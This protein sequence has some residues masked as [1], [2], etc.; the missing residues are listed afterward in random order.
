MRKIIFIMGLLLTSAVSLA[1][2]PQRMSYQAVV[3]DGS[4]ALVSNS[5]VGMRVSILQGSPSGTAQYVETH[6]TSTNANGLVTVSIGSGTVV[7]GSMGA[8]DWSAGPYYIKTETDPTGGTSYTIVGTSEMMSVPYALYAANSPAGPTGPTGPQGPAGAAGANGANGATGATGPAGPTGAAGANGANG[9][10]GATGPAGPAGAV[11]AQGPQGPTGANGATGPAGPA[12]AV[13]AQGPVGPTG[14]DGAT[15]PAGPAGAVG[16]QGPAGPTGATGADG[17][18]GATGAT[19][20]GGVT[21]TTGYHPKF[22]SANTLGN[23]I[24]QENTNGNVAVNVAPLTQYRFYVYNQQLTIN[25]DGQSS[26]FGYRTRDSQN[27]GTSYAVSFTNDATRGYNF[28]GDVYTFGVGGYNY[29][30]YTRCGGVLGA[31]QSG[32]YWGSLGYKSS[33]SITYGVYGSNAYGSGT[34]FAPSN[35]QAGIGGGFFGMVGSINRGSVVGQLNSGELFAGY[36]VGNV[37]TSGKNIEMVNTGTESTPAYAVTSTEAVIYKK[38]KAQLVNGSATVTFD[39]QYAKL[40]GEAPVVTVTPMGQCNGVYIASI[41][42][43]GFTIKELGNGNATVEFSW[44]AVGDRVDARST[45]VPSFLKSPTFDQN[46]NK[47]LFSDSNRS[48]SGEGIWWDGTQF[49]FNKNYPAELNP[50]RE[51]KAKMAG[52]LGR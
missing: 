49:Q 51:E 45:E 42:K 13:G 21:G 24:M 19:G 31:E 1:Q 8:I 30:D 46:V 33:A 36:N 27:D 50:T 3:R 26:M 17:A 40:L 39:P 23:S 4:N 9:A 2:A 15:G 5:S 47:V 12:G 6:T 28:W 14:A 32:A 35:N 22:L 38:G 25:G 43:N 16:A 44:I 41:D 37:Y 52:E 34:G 29:N 20:P 48:Q 18:T 10:T 11:G 7:S